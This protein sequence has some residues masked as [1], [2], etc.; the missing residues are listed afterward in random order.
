LYLKEKMFAADAFNLGFNQ[1]GCNRIDDFLGRTE[2]LWFGMPGLFERDAH[3][4]GPHSQEMSIFPEVFEG[5]LLFQGDGGSDTQMN[6][7]PAFIEHF[8]R[9]LRRSQHRMDHSQQL[10][11]RAVVSVEIDGNDRY[12]RFLDEF[13]DR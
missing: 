3:R 11:H 6:S 13:D 1:F 7:F 12:T 10:E 4:I 2:I 5:I 9:D 8:R